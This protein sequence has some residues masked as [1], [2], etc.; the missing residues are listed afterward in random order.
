VARSRRRSCRI[1]GREHECGG[2]EEEEGHVT[3]AGKLIFS[4][5][6]IKFFLLKKSSIF[7]NLLEK[8]YQTLYF[9]MR[10]FYLAPASMV[11]QAFKTTSDKI[12]RLCSTLGN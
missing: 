2:G 10:K 9:L 7:L 3:G 1:A 4:V 6:K 12:I 11:C 5:L 8:S